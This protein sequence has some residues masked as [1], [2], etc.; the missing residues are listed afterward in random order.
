MQTILVPIDFSAAAENAL[1]YANKLAVRLPAEIV[2]V[3]ANTGPTLTTDSRATLL[4]SLTA[5]AERLRY[6]QLT[7]QDGRR[8]NYHF[9]LSA[10]PLA[11]CLEVLVAGYRAALV[12]AGLTLTDCATV[13]AAGAPLNLLPERVSCPVLLVPPGRQ[14]LPGRLVVAGDFA[15]LGSAQLT[16]LA[17]LGRT[18]AAHFD[19]VQF[20]PEALGDSAASKQVLA[21]SKS[22]QAAQQYL[23]N[24]DTH[25]LPDD[26]A[27]E[28]LSEF[29][30][31]QQAQLLVLGT[32]DGCLVRRFFNPH[33]RRTNA[34]HLRI[35]ALLLPTS[36][37]PTAACCAS[38]GLRQAAEARLMARVSTVTF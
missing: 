18:T 9:H 3:Y 29:C 21:L 32:A 38:C 7:R 33:Y 35:P 10:E 36:T 26:D 13:T 8:I 1:V 14:E 27:L 17:A 6:Q 34:Y 5:L 23:P 25:L 31:R 19:L 12:V 24:S 4:R 2:L 28:G 11:D 22:L 20:Y 30:E 16:P 37:L 15:R